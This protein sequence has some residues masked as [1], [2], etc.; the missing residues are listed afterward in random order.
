M[1]NAMI[2]ISRQRYAELI[3]AEREYNA[4]REI[5]R[6]GLMSHVSDCL[7]EEICQSE[8]RSVEYAASRK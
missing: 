8:R 4:L 5:M 2:M 3:G 6:R 7:M 1:D